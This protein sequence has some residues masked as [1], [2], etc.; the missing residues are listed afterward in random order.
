MCAVAEKAREL[1]LPETKG[2]SPA[3]VAKFVAML[4][5]KESA[6]KL[7]LEN[8]L[9]FKRTIT[10]ASR[11]FVEKF[12]WL[13][14]ISALMKR[15]APDTG[16]IKRYQSMYEIVSQLLLVASLRALSNTKG[17]LDAVIANAGCIGT[18]FAAMQRTRNILVR[19]HV[20]EL[21]AAIIVYSHDG[22]NAVRKTLQGSKKRL[23]AT[24]KAMKFEFLVRWI[25]NIDDPLMTHACLLLINT[26]VTRRAA[27]AREFPA[28][29]SSSRCASMTR[30]KR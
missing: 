1:D 3:T 22:E 21:F 7:T 12:I 19:A 4:K 14:G 6:P 30:W 29:R 16:S 5:Q 13:G 2:E 20:L 17:G 10:A 9:L 8:V 18:L 28:V 23:S 15:I 26:F 27:S 25:R 24:Q 11:K